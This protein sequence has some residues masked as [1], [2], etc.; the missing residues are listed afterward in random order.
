MGMLLN[1]VFLDSLEADAERLLRVNRTLS[2]LAPGQPH[3]EALRPIDL[4]ILRP[5]QDLGELSSDLGK[6]L[7]KTFQRLVRALG[8]EGSRTPDLLSYL[9]FE[10]PYIERLIE[11]GYRDAQARL[12]EIKRFLD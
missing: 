11:L 9:L 1:A 6:T 7:P 10:T 12:D 3:P 2:L 5:S 4:F 8:G